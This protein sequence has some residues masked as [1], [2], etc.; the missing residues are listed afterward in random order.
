MGFFSL[1]ENKKQF[2]VQH[3]VE[4]EEKFDLIYY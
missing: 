1:P 2:S 4:D 3:D